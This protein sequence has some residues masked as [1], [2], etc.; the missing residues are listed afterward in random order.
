MATHPSILAWEIQGVE[1]PGGLN[2]PWSCKESDTTECT[3]TNFPIFINGDKNR[4]NMQSFLK[5]VIIR[6]GRPLGYKKELIIGTWNN[7]DESQN[8]HAE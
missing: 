5:I 6:N 2:S 1:D 3:H 8:N 7:M 4:T